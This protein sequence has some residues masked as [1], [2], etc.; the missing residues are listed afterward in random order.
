MYILFVARGQTTHTHLRSSPKGAK[1]GYH[2]HTWCALIHTKPDVLGFFDHTI[3]LHVLIWATHNNCIRFRIHSRFA[4]CTAC[5][6][7]P[8]QHKF[9]RQKRP[10]RRKVG[11][12]FFRACAHYSPHIYPGRWAYC[13]GYTQW[14][15]YMIGEKSFFSKLTRFTY[16]PI[17]LRFL[18]EWAIWWWLPNVVGFTY[19]FLEP[20]SPQKKGVCVCVCVC[21]CVYTYVCVCVCGVWCVCVVLCVTHIG[22]LWRYVCCD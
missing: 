4:P 15:W 16:P 10:Q 8:L 6:F 3:S 5:H 19:P 20:L 1:V 17:W 7:H 11:T 22:V 18:H 21:V 9:Q 2:T 12:K 13:Q 14:P